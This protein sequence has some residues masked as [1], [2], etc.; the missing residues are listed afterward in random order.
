MDKLVQLG[1]KNARVLTPGAL[2]ASRRHK[3]LVP[4]CLGGKKSLPYLGRSVLDAA[5][6]PALEPCPTGFSFACPACRGPLDAVA[7]DE[8]RCPADSVSYRCLDGIW[9]FLA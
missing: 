9:R 5:T 8:Q 3:D 7:P 1:L 6:P 2:W 4:W